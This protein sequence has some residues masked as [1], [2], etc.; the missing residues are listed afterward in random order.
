M[1]ILY[2]HFLVLCAV[3]LCSSCSLG[4]VLSVGF[5]ASISGSDCWFRFL[6][7]SLFHPKNY[8]I[9]THNHNFPLMNGPADTWSSR[10]PHWRCI[11]TFYILEMLYFKPN[12]TKYPFLEY[13]FPYTIT[14]PHWMHEL[15]D[16]WSVPPSTTILNTTVHRRN[17]FTI[18]PL[19]QLFHLLHLGT[20]V[21]HIFNRNYCYISTSSSPIAIGVSSK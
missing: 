15:S 1:A 3:C 17:L 19:I 5:S 9:C 4:L 2:V 8:S 18:S 14:Y 6:I 10:W 13:N 7:F 12:Q 11:S 20:P 16:N 21:H